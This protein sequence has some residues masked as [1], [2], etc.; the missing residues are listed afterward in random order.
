MTEAMDLERQA[1]ERDRDLAWDLF[2]AQ[3]EHPR[4]PQLARSVLA[5]AP[6]FT[7]MIILIAMHHEARGEPDEAR[8]LLQELI[9]RRDRQYLGALRT[10]RDLELAEGNDAE[11]LRLAET[12]LRED[13]EAHWLD[14]MKRASATAVVV[15]PQTGWRLLDEAVEFCG[16]TEPDDYADALGQRAL[17]FLVSGA[18]PTRFL[19]AAQQA[20]EADP[21][22]SIIATALAYAYLYDYRA[23]EA[24]VILR[25]VLREDPMDEVA[26]GGLIIA[27]SFVDA[28]DGS[29]YTMEDVRRMGMG[30]VA[31]RTLRDKMFGTGVV[32]AL[33]ALDAVLPVDLARSLRPPLDAEAARD[34]GGEDKLLEWHDGQAVGA[35]ELWGD[36]WP[37]RLMT[38]AEVRTMEDA[39][40]DHP[41]DWPQWDTER[42]YFTLLFTDDAGTFV[43]EGTAG[44]LYRRAPGEEDQEISPSLADWLWD[45]VAAFGGADQRPGR[46][47]RRPE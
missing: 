16:R 3:P 34:S 36:G 21:S 32:E 31:W 4:I 6:Q 17:R 11:G 28:L 46:A 19:E 44:H 30:E 12:V 15:D 37:F 39:L 13:P 22:D 45:R 27:R 20:I 5:R 42:E 10:L 35:G 9:G 18:P 14:L 40:A 23:A 2:D 41:E 26:Q 1:I 43:F 38:G 8:R 29:D 47:S 25:R 33:A 7:G 24:E